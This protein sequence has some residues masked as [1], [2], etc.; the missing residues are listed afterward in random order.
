MPSIN[1]LIQLCEIQLDQ[2]KPNTLAANQSALM[3]EQNSYFSYLLWPDSEPGTRAQAKY[4]SELEGQVS[5]AEKRF[6]G[7]MESLQQQV[8][9]LPESSEQEKLA[10]QGYQKQ[11]DS[12]LDRAKNPPRP[13]GELR[14]Y[15]EA[16]KKRSG[17]N[18]GLC[19]VGGLV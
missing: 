4:L 19:A 8:A 18:K 14:T 6:D 2:K 16:V 10:K 1:A 7:Y 12:L 5:K 15:E 9:A 17:L 3:N 13:E 11:I